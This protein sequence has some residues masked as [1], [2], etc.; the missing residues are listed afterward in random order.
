MSDEKNKARQITVW[1]LTLEHKSNDGVFVHAVQ[2]PHEIHCHATPVNAIDFEVFGHVV[3]E[4]VRF[5]QRKQKNQ[6]NR[7]RRRRSDPPELSPC[8]VPQ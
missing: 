4:C 2:A 1:L 3:L 7:P 8:R 6:H 5:L